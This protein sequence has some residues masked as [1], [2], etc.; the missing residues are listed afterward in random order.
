MG[1]I[2]EFKEFAVKGNVMDMAVGVIIGGAFG[3]IVTSLVN[4]ILM[5]PIG[6][7]MGNTD[8]SK[9]RLDISIVRDAI[10]SSE[11]AEPVYWNYGAFIQQCIDFIILAF[12]V[13]L[14]VKLMNGLKKKKEAPAPAPAP[15]PEPQPSKEELLLTEIRDLL[16]EKK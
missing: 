6:V 7:I 5:P 3:K 8:F 1:F 2:K 13:F 9:L 4:D 16:K 11:A 15:A 10:S 12:C 14:L